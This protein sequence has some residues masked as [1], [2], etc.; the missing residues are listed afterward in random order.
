MK[1]TLLVFI[2]VVFLSAIAEGQL[3]K[4]RRYEVVASLGTTQ[5]YGD[6]GGFSKGD[7]YLGIKDFSFRQTRF[8]FTT[9]VKYRIL[10]D[11]SVRLNLVYGGFHST[12]VKGSNE[13]RGFES[14]TSFF[15]PSILGEYYFIKNKGEN[16]FLHM[17]DSRTGFSSLVPALDVYIFTGFGGL[18]YN[19]KPNDKLAPSV[20]E[21]KGFNP[22]IPLGAGINMFYSSYFNFGV[23]L[24][25]RLTF[26][27]NIDGYTSTYS[28]SNDL[29]HFL[30]FTF[31]YK[32]KT[33]YNGL[34]SF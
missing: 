31:T 33:G 12:D 25:G 6:I 21:P 9:A 16:S 30:N 8:N 23:E 20:T 27:D 24:S 15:E 3:W 34:P 32:I 10:D 7:N 26:S 13:N 22:V 18:S 28:K 29:Y 4:L 19:V 17:K 11:V 14:K 1:K 2:G 5:F